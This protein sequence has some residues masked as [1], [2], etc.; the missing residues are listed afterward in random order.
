MVGEVQNQELMA[1]PTRDE[2]KQAAF[3]LNGDSAGGPDDEQSGFVKEMSIVENV[4][5]TQE[6]I[7]DIGLRTKV[8]P[9]VVI[10]LDM[11]KAYDRLSWLFLTRVLRKMEFCERLIGLVFGIVSNNWYSVLISGQPF[12]FFKS[13]R[14][15]KQD[16]TIILSSS[17][18]TSLQLV[19]EVLHTYELAYG[20]RRLDHYLGLLNKVLNKLQSWKGKLL[21]IGGRS[22]LISHVLQSMPIHLLLAVNPPSYVINK[23]HKMFAQ[24]FWKSIIGCKSKQW[25]SWDS[26]CLPCDKGGVGFRSLHDVLKALFYKPW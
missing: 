1:Q 7:T 3:G 13:T 2:V 25:D 5:L 8:G 10:K 4:L 24:F 15:V 21:S 22:V 14:G 20:Q 26:L 6:I 11:S 17:D 16:D 23:L 12:G 19:M 9:N 18:A